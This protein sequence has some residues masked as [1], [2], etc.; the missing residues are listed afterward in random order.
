M[1]LQLP[2]AVQLVEFGED[3]K[4]FVEPPSSM[5]PEAINKD[6]G[7]GATSV[8]LTELDADVPAASVHVSE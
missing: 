2:E 6:G 5:V 4:I 7:G 3:Q 8:K 1:P